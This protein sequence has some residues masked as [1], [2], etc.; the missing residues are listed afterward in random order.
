MGLPPPALVDADRQFVQ[1]TLREA[2]QF[3]QRLSAL[4]YRTY[5]VPTR[6]ELEYAHNAGATPAE[7]AKLGPTDPSAPNAWGL[8]EMSGDTSEWFMD[9][10]GS[11]PAG[12]I[13]GPV[14]GAAGLFRALK[15]PEDEVRQRPSAEERHCFRVVMRQER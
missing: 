12:P 1:V 6:A 14:N 11:P 15:G 7:Q 5:C 10:D 2:R 4:D 3:Y 8:Y 9:S 13:T